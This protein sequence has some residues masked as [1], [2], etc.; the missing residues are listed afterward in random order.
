MPS[1]KITTWK[2]P[3]DVS[4]ARVF[5][6]VP[7]RLVTDR[8]GQEKFS[9]DFTHNGQP[10]RNSSADINSL[11]TNVSEWLS[12]CALSGKWEPYLYV[13]FAC[14]LSSSRNQCSDMSIEVSEYELMT[15]SDGKKFHR[16]KD[17]ILYGSRVQDGEPVI[18]RDFGAHYALLP[19]TPENKSMV[20]TLIEAV[21]SF[22]RNINILFET[23][24]SENIGFL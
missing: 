11:K 5:V 9:V 10:Y 16:A 22:A 7:V 4:G 13:K 23:R 6:D 15:T 2:I 1:K 17:S 3:V 19:N 20:K 21:D 14:E 8:S 12:N 24:L 18:G